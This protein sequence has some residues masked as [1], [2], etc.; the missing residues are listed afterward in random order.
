MKIV[1]TPDYNYVFNDKTG[2]FARW[3]KT[4]NDDP[5][6]SKIGPE[7]LDIEISEICS[8]NCNECYKSNT[9]QGDNMSLDDFRKILDKMPSVI[10]VAFGIGNIP[11][12]IYMRKK[13]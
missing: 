13:K 6:M 5:Q 10:Q 3:G 8:Q 12:P 9:T 2:F 4:V 7:I 1:K 11:K